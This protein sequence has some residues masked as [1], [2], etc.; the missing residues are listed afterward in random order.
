MRANLEDLLEMTRSRCGIFIG[1]KSL[2][3]LDAL[4]RG[5]T[6]AYNK[7]STEPLDYLTGFQEWIE[8]RYHMKSGKHS[9]AEII[10]FFECYDYRAFDRF[11]EHLDEFR[12]YKTIKGDRSEL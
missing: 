12:K 7:Y 2:R 1:C 11:Y 8:E 6:V 3:R 10:N 4:I 9:W 5:Y